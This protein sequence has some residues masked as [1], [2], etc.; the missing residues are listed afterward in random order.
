MWRQRCEHENEKNNELRVRDRGAN[1]NYLVASRRLR[2][3]TTRRRSQTGHN[4]CFQFK[5]NSFLLIFSVCVALAGELFPSTKK[6]SERLT[7]EYAEL[8]T[9]WDKKAT[10][11]FTGND[12]RG[13]T[14]RQVYFVVLTVSSLVIFVIFF[15]FLSRFS[16]LPVFSLMR[17][18]FR[19]TCPNW[20]SKIFSF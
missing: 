13:R 17:D 18:S 12:T 20:P 3:S 10:K 19:R 9:Y 1:E 14:C 16:F 15:L 6:T 8:R 11:P 7:G 4:V 2:N 5:R